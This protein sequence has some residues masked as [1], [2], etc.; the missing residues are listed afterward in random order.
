MALASDFILFGNFI[1]GCTCNRYRII[2]SAR[3]WSLRGNSYGI[4]LA[5]PY[6]LDVQLG[7]NDTILGFD[8]D[9]SVVFAFPGSTENPIASIFGERHPIGA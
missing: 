8:F 2:P 4:Q 5:I 7:C 3:N 1:L 9:K 6:V